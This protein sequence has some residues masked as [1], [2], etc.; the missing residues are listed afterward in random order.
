MAGKKLGKKHQVKTNLEAYTYLIMGDRKIGKSTLVRDIVIEE[1]GDI[2]K[3]L[4]ISV[5]DEDGYEAMHG[6]VY[7]DPHTWAEFVSIVDELVEN[8][9]SYDFKMVSIDTIDELV[10]L[11]T[12]E[13]IRQNNL[14]YRDDPKKQVTTINAAFGGYY[15]GPKYMFKIIHEQIQRL[16]RAK[17]GVFE[18]GHNKIRKR[19]DAETDD[20]YDIVT[21][22]LSND[23]F[24]TFAYKAT[25]ICNITLS[26]DPD[27]PAETVRLMNFRSAGNVDAGSRFNKLPVGV[28]IGARNFIDAVKGAIKEEIGIK[29]DKE[30]DKQAKKDQ[31]KREEEAARFLEEERKKQEEENKISPEEYH[32][33]IVSLFQGASVERKKEFLG[34]LKDFGVKKIQELP[35][36]VLPDAVEFLEAVESLEEE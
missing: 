14:K 20:G 10:R 9:D 2:E 11:A 26:M 17:Y 29:D 1:Y 7:E 18:V 15:E 25:F 35:E 27:N 32:D 21:S 23:E 36:D 4:V 33:R 19:K 5:G 28:E 3:L 12:Q 34:W 24:N 16:R 6:L 31:K 8:Q 13:T 22:N 30:F